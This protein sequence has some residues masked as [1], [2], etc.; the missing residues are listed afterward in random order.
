MNSPRLAKQS[1]SHSTLLESWNRSLWAAI[2]MTL[3]LTAG[4]VR[5]QDD[6]PVDG[7]ALVGD[8]SL[9]LPNNQAGC[10][11]VEKTEDGLQPI[12][13]WAVGSPEKIDEFEFDGDSLLFLKKI[14]RP[15][16]PRDEIAKTYS[17][18]MM[19]HEDTL[20]G[21]M[22]AG[23]ELTEFTG[24]R[25]PPLP[26]KPDLSKIEFG[27]PIELFNGRDLTGWSNHGPG[28][29]N[30]WSG[31]DGILRNDTPK[32][33]F[34]AY[35]EYANL[36]TDDAFGD[37]QLHIEYRLPEAGGNS[38]IYL[39]GMYEVQVTHRG[40]GR[41]SKGGPGALYGRILPTKNAGHPAGQWDVYDITL[42][43]RHVTIVL[44][45]ETIIDNQ[46]I[47]G[48]TGGALQSDVTADGP[49]MLQGDHTTVEYRNIVLR[50]RVE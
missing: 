25:Q 15:L 10:L 20:Y 14:P 2:A 29:I 8:W 35:G 46:P 38:G 45:G 1:L 41:V 4:T 47:V 3:S 32:T 39:R 24:K 21:V 40:N 6:E 34:S 27:E 43:D 42:V 9:D 50:P 44:N 28:T 33:D 48:C 16:A 18:Q 30:G 22:A 49:L 37:F 31:R 19:A 26:E 11:T 12:L 13:L 23:N 5:A 7:A 17:I 36:K